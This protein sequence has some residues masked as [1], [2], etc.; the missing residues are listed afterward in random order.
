[1]R[2]LTKF[3][4]GIFVVLALVCC[5]GAGK[6][7]ESDAKDALQKMLVAQ[8]AGVWRVDRVE[9]TPGDVKQTPPLSLTWLKTD[10][11]WKFAS[12]ECIAC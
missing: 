12:A 10:N 6:P 2:E 8:D 4:V 9:K 7:S 5:S 3:G 11:G 1:M